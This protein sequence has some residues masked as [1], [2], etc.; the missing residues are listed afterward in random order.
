MRSNSIHG[1][2]RPV[3]SFGNRS[4]GPCRPSG[5]WVGVGR[6]TSPNTDTGALAKRLIAQRRVYWNSGTFVGRVDTFL[7]CV[8]QWLPGHA[9][10]LTPLA[11]TLQTA[12]GARRMGAAYRALEAVSFDHGVMNHLR[13]GIVVEGDF[14][15]ADLGSWDTWARF[16][17][18]GASFIGV[19]SQNIGVVSQERHMVATIGLRDLLV[20]HSPS[21]TL[22]CPRNRTQAVREVVRRLS[23]HPRLKAWL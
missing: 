22:I 3:T 12:R 18:A 13:T 19:D 21:A 7:G 9:R 11:G 4:R 15:W 23:A 1:V 14:E 20:V 6:R 5:T 8:T 10:R 16:S 17:P 2:W